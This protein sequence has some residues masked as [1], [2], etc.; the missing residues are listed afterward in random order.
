MVLVLVERRRPRS[1]LGL[2]SDL[3]LSHEVAYRRQH[4]ARNGTHWPIGS[5]RNAP[6]SSI[7][8]LD[9]RFVAV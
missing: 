6:H 4:L 9:H 7:T 3:D 1:L 8:V 2:E 5:Q